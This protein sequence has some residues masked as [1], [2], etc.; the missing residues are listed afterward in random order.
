MLEMPR[1]NVTRFFIPLIDVLTLLFCVF[2][3]MPLARN[4]GEESPE[5]ASRTPEEQVDYLK[6]E[7][8]R[9]REDAL[10]WQR[11]LAEL[12]QQK[13]RNLGERLLVRVLEI[14]GTTGVLFER[15]PE[16]VEIRDEKAAHA[17]IRNDQ[18][19]RGLSD[20]E[21]YYLILYP[22]NRESPYPTRNQRKT[23]ENWF[24]GVPMGFDIPGVAVKG[25]SPS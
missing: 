11:E 17:L 23:Y 25:G 12:R 20:N 24:R 15:D 13:L 1:R 16:R 22:R 21:L 7:V 18:D 4:P 14:D 8:K 10:R 6:Q 5:L 2:L 3:I 19:K 9:L